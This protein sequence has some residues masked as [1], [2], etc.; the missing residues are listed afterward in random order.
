VRSAVFQEV[1]IFD[2][3]KE[4]GR[5]RDDDQ[6]SQTKFRAPLCTIA[7]TIALFEV[8]VSNDKAI[9]LDKTRLAA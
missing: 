5:A 6:P 4:L 9:K 1:E 7:S 8:L 3:W 2:R